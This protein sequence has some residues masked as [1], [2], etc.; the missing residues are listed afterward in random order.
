[1]QFTDVTPTDQTPPPEPT[2]SHPGRAPAMST[3]QFE[4]FAPPKTGGST[5][6][7]LGLAGAALALAAI[8]LVRSYFFPGKPSG[9]AAA[10]AAPAPTFFT[11]QQQMMREALDMAKEARQMQREHMET[12]RRAME[13]SYGEGSFPDGDA[14]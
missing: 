5:R 10:T 12:M 11:T 1:M 2:P 6:L 8:G 4:E 7:V 13:E 14:P 3:P 9:P